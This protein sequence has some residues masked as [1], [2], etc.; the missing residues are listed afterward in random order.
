MNLGNYKREINITTFKIF[1]WHNVLFWP[2]I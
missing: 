2:S 1:K